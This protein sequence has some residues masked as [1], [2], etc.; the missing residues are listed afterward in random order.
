MSKQP[1]MGIGYALFGIA[2][3]LSQLGFVDLDLG[4]VQALERFLERFRGKKTI[5]I[6]DWTGRNG[7]ARYVKQE[8]PF[9]GGFIGVG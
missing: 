4:Q 5:K 2:G 8:T 1:R 7:I 9:E 3:L 6:T